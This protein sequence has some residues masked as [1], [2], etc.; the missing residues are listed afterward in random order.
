MG[1]RL[2]ELVRQFVCDNEIDCPETIYQCDRVIEGAY[3]FIERLC[4]VVGYH[5]GDSDE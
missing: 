4:E 2:V 5:E 1:E 3:G